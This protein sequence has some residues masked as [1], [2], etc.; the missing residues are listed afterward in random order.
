MNRGKRR[1]DWTASIVLS[2]LT[3]ALMIGAIA[4]RPAHLVRA[5]G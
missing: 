1:R 2:V 3:A 5:G 4:C